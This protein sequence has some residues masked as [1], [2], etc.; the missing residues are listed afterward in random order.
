MKNKYA[1]MIIM[2]MSNSS[3]L[4]IIKNT[5]RR[6]QIPYKR[7]QMIM[8]NL[9]MN[10]YQI[11]DVSYSNMSS[12]FFE[13]LFYFSHFAFESLNSFTGYSDHIDCRFPVYLFAVRCLV[14]IANAKL[15]ACFVALFLSSSLCIF[16]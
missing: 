3:E 6:F 12:L 10:I 13:N 7:V 2:F 9:L 14:Y 1:Q 8:N 5:Q 16:C 4:E 11:C 15:C